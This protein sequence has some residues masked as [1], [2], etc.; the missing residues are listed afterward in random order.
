MPF[1]FI[2][3]TKNSKIGILNAYLPSKN[4][5]IANRIPTKEIPM[6]KNKFIIR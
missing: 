3:G 4:K 6:I 5:V 2:R 1:N